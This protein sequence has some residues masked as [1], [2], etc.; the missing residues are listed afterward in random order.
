MKTKKF[1]KKLRK[2]AEFFGSTWQIHDDCG[3][4][5]IFTEPSPN[6]CYCPITAVCLMETGKKHYLWN[7]TKA[8]KLIGL[9]NK[10]IRAITT[11]SDS[12]AAHGKLRIRLLKA[13]LDGQNQTQDQKAPSAEG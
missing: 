6:E 11:A 9:T 4:M 8:G 12:H 2:T 7:V 13:M 5:R 3:Y 10:Q 1:I